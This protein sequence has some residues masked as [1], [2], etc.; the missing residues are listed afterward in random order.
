[1]RKA[2]A[3]YINRHFHPKDEI[4]IDHLFFANGVTALCEMI[5]FSICDAGDGVLFSRPIYQAFQH[6]FATKAKFVHY[7]RSWAL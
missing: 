5:A 3:A 7:T 4:N 2:M 6:D 1:M